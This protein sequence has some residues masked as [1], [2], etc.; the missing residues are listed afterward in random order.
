MTLEA[1]RLKYPDKKLIAVFKPNTYSRTAAFTKEFADSL[2]IA[3]KVFMTEIDC[4]REKQEDYPGVT[5][6]LV[7]KD[8]PDG[9][10]IGEDDVDKLLKYR[11]A[12]LCFMSCASICHLKDNCEC[13]LVSSKLTV[14]FFLVFSS[15]KIGD[16]LEKIFVYSIIV[17]SFSYFHLFFVSKKRYL[18]FSFR[19]FN[20]V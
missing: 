19:F 10:I 1:A 4:N 7:L 8:I 12:V 9:E 13:L 3:D 16:T 15:I 14:V 11:F 2:K 5:S 18:Y 17:L 6:S 20:S